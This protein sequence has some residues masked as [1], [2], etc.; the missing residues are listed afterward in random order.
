MELDKILKDYVASIEIPPQAMPDAIKSMILQDSE[1]TAGTFLKSLRQLKISGSE[2]L[3]LLGN[4]K[5]GNAEYRRI[6]ENPHLKFDELLTILDH[7]VLS[8][9]DYRVLLAAA[10]HRR[11]LREERRRREEETLARIERELE[12]EKLAA[13]TPVSEEP[14]AQQP[15]EEI[16]EEVTEET[17]EELTEEVAEETAEEAAEE[18]TEEIAEETSEEITEEA[19]EEIAEEVAEETAEELAE[20]TVE[21]SAEEAPEEI[22]E[23]TVE[24]TDTEVIEETAVETVA[25]IEEE[26]ANT[27]AEVAENTTEKA[28]EETSEQPAAAAPTQDEHTEQPDNKPDND[29]YDDEYDDDEYDDEYEEEDYDSVEYEE[30]DYDDE[31]EDDDD[32]WDYEI[33]ENDEYE[34]YSAETLGN[35]LEEL[36]DE[37]GNPLPSRRSKPALITAFVLA[38]VVILCGATYK[39]L[40]YYEIIPSYTYAIPET[41]SQQIGS[42]A[43]L[44]DSVQSARSLISYTLPNTI[45]LQNSSFNPESLSAIGHRYVIHVGETENGKKIINGFGINDD[46]TAG[47]KFSADVFDTEPK[48]LY[49]YSASVG[50]T[51]YFILA[52]ETDGQ[53]LIKIYEEEALSKNEQPAADFAQS[54]GYA[55]YSI[56]ADGF[57]SVSYVSMSLDTANAEKPETFVPGITADGRSRAVSWGD[58]I[59]P[60]AAA[61]FNYYVIVR[62]PLGN[63]ADP[64]VKAVGVGDANGYAIGADGFYCADYTAINSASHSRITKIAFDPALTHKDTDIDGAINVSML[65][66]GDS[67]IAVPGVDGDSSSNLYTFSTELSE[68]SVMDGIAQDKIISGAY[69]TGNV[70]TLI[71]D[72]DAPMQYNI[73]LTTME[74]ADLPPAYKS[75]SDT[76][77]AALTA[78][79]NKAVLHIYDNGEEQTSADITA[80]GSSGWRSPATTDAAQLAVL[81]KGNDTLIG[82]PV[83]YFDGVTDVY[84]YMLYSY[85]GGKLTEKG[86]IILME[87][88][89]REISSRI[90]GDFV[91]T[92]WDNRIIVADTDNVKIISDTEF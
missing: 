9:E 88:S 85:S 79:G 61:R 71:T 80:E 36:V 33:Y 26:T 54:G 52:A 59:L 41:F 66:A 72:G 5:I 87:G 67:K 22:T 49:V 83:I 76:L 27:V 43:E 69:C 19:A 17:A 4:S 18:N 82:L 11:N 68:P 65:L 8:S 78:D 46:G 34:D 6:E 38:A 31:Y 44:A 50:E 25:E 1:M 57:Y 37:D 63:D 40:R 55:G 30:D 15:V 45:K 21:E 35:A 47:D 92:A 23:E 91:I 7:S 48:R 70:I 28:V 75:L 2:F 77:S 42:Y 14:P 10:T 56:G 73:D 89:Y 74:N 86:S 29:K 62:L 3:E 24:V 81:Q 58:I 90:V 16:S 12:Q 20:E 32:D 60:Y 84:K 64:T 53:T 39:L 13:Q 51:G